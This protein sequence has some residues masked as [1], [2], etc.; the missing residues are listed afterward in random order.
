MIKRLMS[1]GMV[2]TLAGLSG[3]ASAQV[4]AGHEFQVNVA[5]TGAQQRPSIVVRPNGD[6]VVVFESY[7]SDGSYTGIVGRR[8]DATGAALGGEFQVNTT[9]TDDQ[10]RPSVAADAKGNFVV[11]WV[12]PDGSSK[13]VF[14]QRFDAAGARRGAEFQINTYTTGTQGLSGR[15]GPLVA[16]AADG[17]FVVAWTSNTGTDGSD[18]SVEARR[19]DAAGIAQ[20]DEFR[21][22]AFTTGAQAVSSL[23]MAADGAFIVGFSS[24]GED[25]SGFA[26]VARRFDASA[27]PIGGDFVVS[28][29]TA[30]GQYAPILNM[31]DDHSFVVDFAQ[32]DTNS[33][34]LRA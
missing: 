1:M 32:A 5:T 13:G 23:S 22:N 10:Y 7:G 6:F 34:G 28:A 19:Y 27:N 18:A 2:A 15:A 14:G 25:G 11:V 26:A 33:F 12:G 17:R 20:G 31:A 16:S 3:Q 21:V 24:D 4:L 29:S 30:A 8:F 9:T